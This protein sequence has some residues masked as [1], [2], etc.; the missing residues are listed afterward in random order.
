[1]TRVWATATRLTA[2]LAL[3]ALAFVLLLAMLRQVPDRHVIRVDE[4]RFLPGSVVA[5]RTADFGVQPPLAA[6]LERRSLPHDWRRTHPV[7]S[8]W[9]Y[10]D[11]DLNVAPNRLWAMWLPRVATSASVYVNGELIGREGG[12]SDEAVRNWNRSL[13]FL[14]PNGVLRPGANGFAIQI[15]AD[16]PGEGLLREIHLAPSDELAPYQRRAE[17]L[18][19]TA[20]YA[21]VS[22]M[23]VTA[24]LMCVLWLLR[25]QDTVFG[26]YALM[27]AV[28]AL[29]DVYYLVQDYSLNRGFADWLWHASLVAFVASACLFI[30]RFLDE[31]DPPFERRLGLWVIAAAVVLGVL[32]SG[33]PD[34]FHAVGAPV[35]DT[36]ALIVSFH[37]LWRV[38]RRYLADASLGI[39]AL[40]GA[41]TLTSVCG[42]HDWLVMIEVLDRGTGYLL[43]YASPA[44]MVVFGVVLVRRFSQALA[45]L[46]RLNLRLEQRVSAREREIEANYLRMRDLERERAVAEERSRLMRDMHDGIGGALISTLAMVEAGRGEPAA[47]AVALRSAIEDLRLTIDSL[48]TVDGDLGAVLGMLRQ[49]LQ[50]RLEAAGL[51]IDWAVGDLAPMPGLGANDALQILRILQEG[52]NNV[53]KHARA[54]RIRISAG[55][56]GGSQAWV[57]LV[58][59]GSGFDQKSTSPGRGLN[60]MRRRAQTIGARLE[61][62]PTSAGTCIRLEVPA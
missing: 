15:V 49:R 43:P 19:V 37:P 46:E 48:D 7:E 28:W 30:A 31:R 62:R 38:V 29:H 53:L 47:V 52:I 54:T 61:I 33:F 24:L 3:A 20:L 56:L 57:E 60:N 45:D 23:A 21:I 32:A 27:I 36:A 25:L 50:P 59:D 10:F 58:D 22:F 11:L 41:G 13:Y 16:R 1:M 14:I 39:G 18:G 35:L 2:V 12:A 42:V 44:I 6:K 51:A 17:L 55:M 26:W 8:G 5:G 4:T 40:V 34:A 9:Y